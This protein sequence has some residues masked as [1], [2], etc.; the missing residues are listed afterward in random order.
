MYAW[1][2]DGGANGCVNG[3]CHVNSIVAPEIKVSLFGFRLE[4]VRGR[5]GLPSY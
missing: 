5:V 1:G 3:K 4:N 2:V